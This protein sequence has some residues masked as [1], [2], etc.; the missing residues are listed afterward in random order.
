MAAKMGETEANEKPAGK[1]TAFLSGTAIPLAEVKDGVF[2]EGI[3][4]DGMAIIPESDTLYAPADAEIAALMP[5]SRHAC[6]LKLENGMEVLLHIGCLLYTSPDVPGRPAGTGQGSLKEV[7]RTSPGRRV[8][9][10]SV[11]AP[12]SCNV[13]TFW[14]WGIPGPYYMEVTYDK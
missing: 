1:L 2:S 11:R 14:P 13:T 10:H 8:T 9:R 6:G 4:G 5:D 7:I 12:H 3:L